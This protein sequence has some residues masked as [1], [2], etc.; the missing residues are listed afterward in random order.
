MNNELDALILELSDSTFKKYS[1][2]IFGCFNQMGHFLQEVRGPNQKIK[3][4]ANT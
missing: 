4:Y 1:H 2:G 3:E